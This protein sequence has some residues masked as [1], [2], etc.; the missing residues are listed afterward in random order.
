MRLTSELKEKLTKEIVEYLFPKGWITKEAEE[1][2]EYLSGDGCPEMKEARTL[3]AQHPDFIVQTDSSYWIM[4]RSWRRSRVSECI[5]LP[6]SY[7]A[8]KRN[9]NDYT[10]TDVTFSLDDDDH[11][12]SSYGIVLPPHLKKKMEGILSK[13]K[14]QSDLI[15]LL[16]RLMEKV[17]SDTRLKELF[18]EL[19]T[20]IDNVL[21]TGGRSDN[22]E[23]DID[24]INSIIGGT[25]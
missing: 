13:M 1:I 9:P 8:I 16:C 14:D 2:T 15:M 19:E 10:R 12:Q 20:V 6:F 18:P 22:M 17:A 24:D 25:V 7:P 11:Y 23:T 4:C 21:S 3:L 5:P